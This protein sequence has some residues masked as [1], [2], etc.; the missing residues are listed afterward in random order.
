MSAKS[1]PKAADDALLTAVEQLKLALPPERP[2]NELIA[3]GAG[4]SVD[5]NQVVTVL[6]A[7]A[8][9]LARRGSPLHAVQFEVM[10][11]QLSHA[12][13]VV[14]AWGP[15]A[16]TE[17]ALD[18]AIS[19][20]E[21]L[22][23]CAVA[24]SA[25]GELL[26]AAPMR[27]TLGHLL[28]TLLALAGPSM[29]LS[30]ARCAS[31]L[32]AVGALCTLPE[33]DSAV[34][35]FFLPGVATRLSHLASG[36]EKASSLVLV[37][38]LAAVRAILLSALRA[39]ERAGQSEERAGQS[40]AAS[41]AVQAAASNSL[42]MHEL[43]ARAHGQQAHATA[44]SGDATPSSKSGASDADFRVQ[45][46][47]SWFQETARRL[48]PLLDRVC[49]AAAGSTWRARHQLMVVLRDVLHH[50]ALSV[51]S[52]VPRL[53]DYVYAGTRD[54]C[55]SPLEHAHSA[56]NCEPRPAGHGLTIRSYARA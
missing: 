15:S 28:S 50:C 36:D 1:F 19:G 5:R 16:I 38:L 14:Q 41:S 49:T 29:R 51:E 52:C 48:A 10:F 20:L 22:L 4:C 25:P 13:S 37:E 23:S 27:S 44:D 42:W 9:T 35:G 26:C 8:K 54:G 33:M 3:S 47:R 17:M 43:H 18:A 12:L 30:G 34:L 7:L 6:R 31:C 32:R 24:A 40:D 46:S 21:A 39:E 56:S 55:D 53:L 11:R 2:T 45:R